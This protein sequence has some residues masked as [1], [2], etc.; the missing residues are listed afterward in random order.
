MWAAS[1]LYFTF[2]YNNYDRAVINTVPYDVVH[3]WYAAHRTLT[4]ELRRPENELWVKLKPGKVGLGV[5]RLVC[6]WYREGGRVLLRMC[7]CI[8]CKYGKSFRQAPY[9][10]VFLY[11]AVLRCPVLQYWHL[12]DGGGC[13]YCPKRIRASG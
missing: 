6:V 13:S 2:R 8:C 12:G 7:R 5:G 11:T 4:T 3:R 10:A 1:Y 9:A